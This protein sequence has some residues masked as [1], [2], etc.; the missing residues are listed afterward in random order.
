MLI[1]HMCTDIIMYNV[2]LHFKFMVMNLNRTLW[3]YIYAIYYDKGQIPW[4]KILNFNYAN[5]CFIKPINKSNMSSFFYFGA[6]RIVFFFILDRNWRKS[7]REYSKQSHYREVPRWEILIEQELQFGLALGQM[8]GFPA[9]IGSKPFD[10]WN[11]HI[12]QMKWYNLWHILIYQKYM[13]S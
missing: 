7:E 2:D 13:K 10:L 11:R 6:Q 8:A 4:G 5:L 12:P 9:F 1:L 3:S